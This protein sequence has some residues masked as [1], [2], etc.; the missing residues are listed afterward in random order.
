[1]E[2]PSAIH[3]GAPGEARRH[4]RQRPLSLPTSRS[5]WIPAGC[6]RRPAGSSGTPAEEEHGRGPGK[7]GP[8]PPTSARAVLGCPSACAPTAIR[9][10]GPPPGAGSADHAVHGPWPGPACRRCHRV[11]SLVLVNSSS[12]SSLFRVSADP[13]ISA[14]CTGGLSSECHPIH[15][16]GWR[17][18]LCQN[19]LPT[20]TISRR[21]S[22]LLVTAGHLPGVSRSSGFPSEAQFVVHTPLVSCSA[23]QIACGRPS[24]GSWAVVSAP[25]GKTRWAGRGGGQGFGP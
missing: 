1:V 10:G 9:W 12:R 7:R 17:C 16:P 21:P 24:A 25:S 3:D 13:P 20:T 11:P 15:V 8:E 14:A 19:T 22:G 18:R 4:W 23:C 2:P 6:K 5:G